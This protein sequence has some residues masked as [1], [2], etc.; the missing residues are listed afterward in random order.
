MTLIIQIALGILLGFLLIE[1]RS[2][3]AG[4]TLLG[5]KGLLALVAVAAVVTAISYLPDAI[6][7]TASR[8]LDRLARIGE[9]LILLPGIVLLFAVLWAGTYG[10]VLIARKVFRRWPHMGEELGSFI[11]L[12]LLNVLMIWPLDLYL[13]WQT[14][15]GDFYRSVDKWSREAGFADAAAS[16]LSFS[17]TLWPW[18]VILIAQRLGVEFRRD[19]AAPAIM[20]GEHEVGE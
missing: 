12:G 9:K 17:L 3:L 7:V 14:P 20:Q 8:L 6:G 10:F 2:K 13:Q 19:E 18:V 5:L 15:Y 16:F 1:Y 4:W 11:F